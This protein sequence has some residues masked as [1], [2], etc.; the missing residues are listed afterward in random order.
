ML[1]CSAYHRKLI[2][3]RSS[4]H[5][6]FFFFIGMRMLFFL[7]SLFGKFFACSMVCTIRLTRYSEIVIANFKSSRW[8]VFVLFRMSNWIFSHQ[9]IFDSLTFPSS[10]RQTKTEKECWNYVVFFS[11]PPKIQLYSGCWDCR[12][13]VAGFGTDLKI[14]MN[15][16]P[17]LLA[18]L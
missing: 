10:S 17:I 13:V 6:F 5:V 9:I 12:Q 16:C 14:E 1:F 11:N 18:S 2:S 8:V 4:I 3:R 7:F 15:W